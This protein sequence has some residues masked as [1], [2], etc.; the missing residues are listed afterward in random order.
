MEE[1]DNLYLENAQLK[2]TLM[3]IEQENNKV[4]QEIELRLNDLD[5]EQ[6]MNMKL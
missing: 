3:K 4:M 2:D 5:P 6:K 1:S